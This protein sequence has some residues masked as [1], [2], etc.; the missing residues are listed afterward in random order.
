MK[1]ALIAAIPIA[2]IALAPATH[3]DVPYKVILNG[4]EVTHPNGVTVVCT[5]AAPYTDIRIQAVGAA[6]ITP[7]NQVISVTL[8]DNR[9]SLWQFNSGAYTGGTSSAGNAAAT[10][11]G[12]SYKITGNIAASGAGASVAPAGSPVTP[13]EF[14]VTCP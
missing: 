4:Q 1:K 2:A 14:D 5:A 10:K 8:F 12:N 3:A 11:S 6:Q 13:F 7:A 9:G